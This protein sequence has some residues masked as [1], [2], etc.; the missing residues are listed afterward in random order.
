[1]S[2]MSGTTS[3]RAF[4]SAGGLILYNATGLL[5]CT[6]LFLAY[7]TLHEWVAFHA[8]RLELPQWQDVRDGFMLS[9]VAIFGGSLVSHPLY[10]LFSSAYLFSIFVPALVLI[11]YFNPNIL[12][13]GGAHLLLV[14]S[15][16]LSLGGVGIRRSVTIKSPAVLNERDYL[17]ILGAV[18]LL[19]T[20]LVLAVFRDIFSV[21]SLSD[22]YQQRA[23]YRTRANFFSYFIHWQ[24]MLFSPLCIFFGVEKK[25]RSLIA[26]GVFG[27]VVVYGIT[28][29]KMAPAIA[30]LIYVAGKLKFLDRLLDYRPGIPIA[31][32]V[33]FSGIFAYDLLIASSPFLTYY[34]LDR[35]FVG[36][37]VMQLMTLEYYRD[38]PY[39]LWSNSF[40]SALVERVYVEDPFILLGQNFFNSDVRANSGFFADGFINLGTW[41]VLSMSVAAALTT[42]TT[43]IFTNKFPPH[44]AAMSL[45]YVMGFINGPL[46]VTLLTNGLLLFWLMML[47]SPR[48]KSGNLRT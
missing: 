39:A 4:G 15:L 29:F 25:K 41:G 38:M 20:F 1:M 43:A 16:I 13:E 27:V 47:V 40:L 45:P 48:S 18:S 23:A 19:V 14:S 8:F 36:T 32:L 2:M 5:Y 17:F 37:G 30:A 46:Q 24:M 6:I 33:I 7:P 22:V 42:R 28:A 10:R 3:A 35:N 12:H 44:F 26:I 31:F 11:P 34:I 21:A 9:M